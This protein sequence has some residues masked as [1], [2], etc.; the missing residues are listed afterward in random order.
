MINIKMTDRRH[1][2]KIDIKDGAQLADLTAAMYHLGTA[3]AK[4]KDQ[5][6]DLWQTV[7]KES[8]RAF[9]VAANGGNAQELMYSLL[10]EVA[11]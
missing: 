1:K 11:E 8:V 6:E 3:L 5:D 4:V 9:T 10:K 2:V 7:K